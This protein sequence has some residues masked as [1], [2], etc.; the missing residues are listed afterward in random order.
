MT[1]HGRPTIVRQKSIRGFNIL[2]NDCS[3]RT[4][5]HCKQ[6]VRRQFAANRLFVNDCSPPAVV[7]YKP[8]QFS[9]NG[10]C[11]GIDDRCCK[12]QTTGIPSSARARRANTRIVHCMKNQIT[13]KCNYRILPYPRPRSAILDLVGASFG[14]NNIQQYSKGWAESSKHVNTAF[15][16]RLLRKMPQ[17]MRCPEFYGS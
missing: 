2:A 1:F 17:I 15:Y 6:K 12:I 8:F 5:I 10:T 4:I 3:P 13:C 16:S 9:R 11:R 14:D 7:R